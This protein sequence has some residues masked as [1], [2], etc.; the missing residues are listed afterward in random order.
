FGTAILG[1]SADGAFVY[2]VETGPD[3]PPPPPPP[4]PEQCVVPTVVGLRL[5]AAKGQITAADCAVGTVTRVKSPMVGLVLSQTPAPG[6]TL[7]EG[8]LVNLTVG[9]R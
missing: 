2:A 5:N 8:G 9:R 4:P 3:G 6:T 7:P 1:G